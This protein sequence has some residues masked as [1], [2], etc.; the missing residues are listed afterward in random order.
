MK[1]RRWFVTPELLVWRY[2]VE[3]GMYSGSFSSFPNNPC[4]IEGWERGRT[5][6]YW[7]IGGDLMDAVIRTHSV[8]PQNPIRKLPAAYTPAY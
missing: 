3:C 2:M 7:T 1:S 8:V 4:G 5:V 6:F